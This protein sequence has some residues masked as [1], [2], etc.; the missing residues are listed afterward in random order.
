MLKSNLKK[1]LI[2]LSLYSTVALVS[3]CDGLADATNSNEMLLLTTQKLEDKPPNYRPIPHRYDNVK[4]V[5]KSSPNYPPITT[6]S[7]KSQIALAK[8]LRRKR[9]K[10]Y[11][12]W[13]CPHCHEQKELFGKPAFKL[14]RYIE[15]AD[16]NEGRQ[17]TPV[18]AKAKIQAYPTWRIKSKTVEGVQSLETLANL[19]GYRGS[20]NFTS[21]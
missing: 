4:Q 5:A 11:G 20:R 10:F 14:V 7:N 18:C 8:H 2:F 19:S 16:A 6:T 21:P 12:A 9:V 1:N 17:Q 3:G 13:W 15:C